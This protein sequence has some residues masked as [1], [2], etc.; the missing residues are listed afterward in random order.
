[1]VVASYKGQAAERCHNAE[2]PSSASRPGSA[3]HLCLRGKDMTSDLVQC[4]T[5]VRA[6]D[7]AAHALILLRHGA[8]VLPGTVRW[9]TAI[10]RRSA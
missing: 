6:G 8:A 1:M 5:H 10:M 9:T 3:V 7:N 2:L 4:A